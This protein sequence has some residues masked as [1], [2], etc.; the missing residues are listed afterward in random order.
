MSLKSETV[1]SYA[2]EVFANCMD[3]VSLKIH[4]YS[5]IS[6]KFCLL[7]MNRDL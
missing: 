7:Q 6:L 5:L 3:C 4:P 1:N 2:N